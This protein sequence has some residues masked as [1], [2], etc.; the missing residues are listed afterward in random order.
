MYQ[1]VSPSIVSGGRGAA[2]DALLSLH[3]IMAFLGSQSHLAAVAAEYSEVAGGAMNVAE[4][5]V[6][7]SECFALTGVGQYLSCQNNVLPG[8]W[9]EP[10]PNPFG[11]LSFRQTTAGSFKKLNSLQQEP[12]PQQT[13]HLIGQCLRGISGLERR[14]LPLQ[15]GAQQGTGVDCDLGCR[16]LVQQSCRL[17]ADSGAHGAP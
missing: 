3:G 13:S 1:L 2:D 17:H 14:S 4:V 16:S 5:K 15:R 12:S 6:R 9:R 11:L 7:W 10:G 8:I